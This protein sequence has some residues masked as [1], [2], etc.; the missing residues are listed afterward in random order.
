MLEILAESGLKQLLLLFADGDSAVFRA[1]IESF[2]QPDVSS[3]Y[4]RFHAYQD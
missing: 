4:N 1:Q 2:I 3:A